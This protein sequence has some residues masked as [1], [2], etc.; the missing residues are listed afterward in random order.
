MHFYAKKKLKKKW[1]YLDFL[2]QLVIQI[3][4]K[5]Q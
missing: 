2:E 3:E 1:L 4:Q 5:K